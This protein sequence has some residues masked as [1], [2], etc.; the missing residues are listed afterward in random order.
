MPKPKALLLSPAEPEVFVT[1]KQYNKKAGELLS[2]L[3]C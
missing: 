1:L 3:P 2:K